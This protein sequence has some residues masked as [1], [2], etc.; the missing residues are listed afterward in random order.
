[1]DVLHLFAQSPV[2]PTYG[3]GFEA[4]RADAPLAWIELHGGCVA[5]GTTGAGFAFDNEG[6]RHDVL[7]R[8]YRLASRLVTNREWLAFMEDGGY[9]R[10]DPYGCWTAGRGKRGLKAGRRRSTGRAATPAGARWA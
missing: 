6:P 5:I 1:M 8:P 3:P 10:A 2:S 9:A 4:A 7:L